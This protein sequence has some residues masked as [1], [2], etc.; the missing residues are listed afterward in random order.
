M[1]FL[2]LHLKKKN[3]KKTI[4]NYDKKR[5]KKDHKKHEIKYRFF[6]INL[7][8]VDTVMLRMSHVEKPNEN[9]CFYAVFREIDTLSHRSSSFYRSTRVSQQGS[10]LR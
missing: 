10:P 8:I 6:L 7:Q 5:E 9:Y 2:S 1:Y 4:K 3:D